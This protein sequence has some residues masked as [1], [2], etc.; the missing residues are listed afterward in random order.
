LAGTAFDF[1][2]IDVPCSKCGQ[3]DKQRLAQLVA[4]DTTTCDYCGAVISLTDHDWRTRLAEEAEK[5]KQIKP[6]QSG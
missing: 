2:R 5:F 6:T 1:V 4:S 3:N